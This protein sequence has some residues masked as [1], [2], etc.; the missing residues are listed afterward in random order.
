[1]ESPYNKPPKNNGTFR[2]KWLECVCCGRVYPQSLT[3]K[4][5]GKIYCQSC[6]DPPQPTHFP[7]RHEN[8]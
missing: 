3:I 4:Q 8:R 5:K 6:Y 7:I 1:M 2:E